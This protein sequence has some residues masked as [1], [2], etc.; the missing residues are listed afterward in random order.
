[1]GPL[2]MRGLIMFLPQFVRGEKFGET[3]W[4]RQER[5]FSGFLR[6]AQSPAHGSISLI[7]LENPQRSRLA[8]SEQS[9]EALG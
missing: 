3:A 8:I 5:R 7:A 2:Q 9:D 1:M 4:S 6:I